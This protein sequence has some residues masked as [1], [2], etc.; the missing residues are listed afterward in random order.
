MFGRLFGRREEPEDAAPPAA[1]AWDLGP[2]SFLRLGFVAPEGLAR[3][4]LEVRGVHALDLS[5]SV[6]RVLTVEALALGRLLMWHGERGAVAMGRPVDRPDVERLFDLGEFARLFDLDGA[7]NLV[8]NRIAEPADFA[9]WTAPVYRQEAAHE[10]FRREAD[11]LSG[12]S[13]AGAGQ[14]FDFYRLVDDRRR[15]ALEAYVH[16]GGRTDVVVAALLD[17]SVVEEIWSG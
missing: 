3:A 2:G 17:E 6:R 16:D 10:A 12:E 1:H 4:E 8:L 11:P 7:G 15:H 5:G 13:G 14:A 9:G